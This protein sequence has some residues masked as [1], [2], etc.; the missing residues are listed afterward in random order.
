LP[1]KATPGDTLSAAQE[2]ALAA[3]LPG[4]TI[5]ATQAAGVDKTTVYR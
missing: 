2:A 4:H 5:T 3:L 1:R